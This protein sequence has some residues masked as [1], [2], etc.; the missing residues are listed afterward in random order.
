MCG[1]CAS[2]AFY[3]GAKRISLISGIKFICARRDGRDT[4]GPGAE[5]K[6]GIWSQV[7]DDREPSGV[8]LLSNTQQSARCSMLLT[9]KLTL[10]VRALDFIYLLIYLFIYLLTRLLT[11]RGHPLCSLRAGER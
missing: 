1:G 9:G 6:E 8:F 2:D 3:N 5:H 10:L 11:Q 7:T 4:A